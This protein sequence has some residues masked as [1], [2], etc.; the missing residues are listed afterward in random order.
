MSVTE[1]P[2]APE[3]VK[4]MDNPGEWIASR[5]NKEDEETPE[6]TEVAATEPAQ[7]QE[8]AE[9]KPAEPPAPE[10]PKPGAW[11]DVVLDD[12]DHGFFKGKKASDLYESYRHSEAA[13]QKATTERNELQRRLAAL[14]AQQQQK[15]PE[16]QRPVQTEK[17]QDELEALV[18]D[19]PKRFVEEVER[20]AEEKARAV[21]N[22]E[23]Q[24][25]TQQ[26]QWENLQDGARQANY[27]AFQEVQ[28]A[29]KVSEEQALRLV[30]ATWPEM[31]EYEKQ[32]GPAIWANA[33]NYLGLIA[34]IAGPPPSDEPA[35]TVP[36]A[37]AT[38]QIENPPIPNPPGNRKP[39][40]IATQPTRTASPLNEDDRAVRNAFAE[41]LGER[42]IKIDKERLLARAGQKGKTNGK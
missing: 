34:R 20:R 23:Y 8:P 3:S 28:R 33:G 7:P 6:T 11:R 10:A 38:T 37:P 24:N 4:F 5:V 9:A 41:A 26:S 29:Y 27:Y 30:R 15:P 14:E 12:V 25:R 17:P 22:T 1:A 13:M 32:Y 35:E 36:A 21:F 39:A 42:G 16:P 19:D 40:A 31:S 2:A 18:F